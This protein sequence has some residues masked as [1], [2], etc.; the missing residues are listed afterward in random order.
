MR[1]SSSPYSGVTVLEP[2]QVR[3][4]DFWAHPLMW[5][6]TLPSDGKISPFRSC[7]L[8]LLIRVYILPVFEKFSDA[9]IQNSLLEIFCSTPIRFVFCDCLFKKLLL[10]DV[11]LSYIWHSIEYNNY[12]FSDAAWRRVGG[13]TAAIFT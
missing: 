6:V 3:F 1:K 7:L 2:R 4:Q 9:P 12:L 5:I 13:K 11:W 8:R 10:E